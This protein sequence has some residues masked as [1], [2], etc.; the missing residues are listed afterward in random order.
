MKNRLFFV[1]SGEHRTLPHAEIRAILQA[2]RIDFK[3]TAASTK[4]LRVTAD[5][6]ALSA[7]ASRSVMFEQCGIEIAATSPGK[8]RLFSLLSRTNLSRHFAKT[9]S[10]AVRSLRIG[11][12]LR[13]INRASLEREIGAI[14]HENGH[15]VKVNLDRPEVTFLCIVSSR[16]LLLGKVTHSRV[17]G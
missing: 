5:P 15:G 14:L 10:F 7:V 2:Q 6:S 8:K 17:P 4:L 9:R 3:E 12:A 11:G 1:V 13:Y 16:G